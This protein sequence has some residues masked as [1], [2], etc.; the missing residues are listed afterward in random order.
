MSTPAGLST[1]GDV[2]G[3]LDLECGV[4]IVG[5]GAGGAT[6][7][8]ELA[9]ATT[10]IDPGTDAGDAAA[11]QAGMDKMSQKFR[12]LGEEVYVDADRARKASS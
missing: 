9:E 5:S 1:Q 7:A 2:T 6:M 12:E 8:V 10:Q 4:V 3:D 11:L